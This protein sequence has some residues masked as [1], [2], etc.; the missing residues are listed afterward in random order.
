MNKPLSTLVQALPA[1]LLLVAAG[2]YFLYQHEQKQ[3]AARQ[4]Q[5]EAARAA[6]ATPCEQALRD[7]LTKAGIGYVALRP[8]YQYDTTQ[9]GVNTGLVRAQLPGDSSLSGPSFRCDVKDGVVV[10]LE[11]VS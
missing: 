10:A 11:R 8:D 4:A 2:G 5:V 9:L 6:F 3:E 7:T 1:V